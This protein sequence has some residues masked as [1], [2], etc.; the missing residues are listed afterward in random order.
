VFQIPVTHLLAL[1]RE[2]GYTGQ[3]PHVLEL[4]YP[5]EDVV[6]WGVTAKIVHHLLEV[7]IQS[8]KTP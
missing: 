3:R 4:T 7:L 6:I 8:E 2:K 1:H 5:F